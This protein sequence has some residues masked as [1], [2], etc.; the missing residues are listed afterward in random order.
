MIIDLS[1]TPEDTEVAEAYGIDWWHRESEDE[2]VLALEAPLEV[3]VTIRRAGNKYVLDGRISG[4]I[5]VRCDR[6]LES[7]HREVS[8]PFHLFLQAVPSGPNAA[9]VELLDEDMEVDFIQGD[10]VNL[11][12]IVREQVFLSL[13]LKCLCSE[14]C[15]GLCPRCGANLNRGICNCRGGEGH[16]AFSKLKEL[17][18]VDHRGE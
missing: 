15:R 1:R 14:T 4:G 5:Q 17:K 7:Y 10:Q 8:A 18:T 6:C 16:P 2:Q 3:K 13:P 11:D 9:E 12:E